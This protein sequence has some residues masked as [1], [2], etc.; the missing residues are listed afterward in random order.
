MSI[1]FIGLKD[2]FLIKEFKIIIEK[3]MIE[4]TEQKYKIIQLEKRLKDKNDSKNKLD[5]II[6]QSNKILNF[7][8][9]KAQGGP[10]RKIT[11]NNKLEIKHSKGRAQR[12][13]YDDPLPLGKETKTSKLSGMEQCPRISLDS[14]ENESVSLKNNNSGNSYDDVMKELKS[15]LNKKLKS[16]K[17]LKKNENDENNTG[18][19]A[20]MSELKL[21][22]KIK[23]EV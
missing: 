14:N 17:I 6:H 19:N 9:N 7:I 5:S 15:C 4:N 21:K 1:S 8:E 16:V 13:V 23:N 11:D 10:N 20:V 2:S 18:Y 12:Q 3:L 22:L